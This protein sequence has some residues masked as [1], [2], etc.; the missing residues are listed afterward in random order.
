MPDDLIAVDGVAANAASRI[1]ERLPRAPRH[2]QILKQ[3]RI[4]FPNPTYEHVLARVVL[5]NQLYGTNLYAVHEMAAH[6]SDLTSQPYRADTDLV[7]RIARP[8]ALDRRYCSFASKYAHF[9]LDPE[10]FHI[11]DDAA[12]TVLARHARVSMKAAGEWSYG[13]FN[14]TAEN[15]RI[16][17]GLRPDRSLDRYLWIAGMHLRRQSP[18]R[19]KMFNR[20]LG[21][22]FDDITNGPDLRLVTQ[23]VPPPPARRRSPA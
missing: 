20:E 16:K 18:R 21:T 14:R 2:D 12:L 15:L 5:V 6:I 22:A 9:F 10:Q 8:P 19:A 11:L 17:S 1:F 3:A 13:D 4:V 23:A 7:E